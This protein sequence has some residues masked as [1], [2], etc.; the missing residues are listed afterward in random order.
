MSK[1]FC[2]SSKIFYARPNPDNSF[3]VWF[4]DGHTERWDDLRIKAEL[5]FRGLEF[6]KTQIY[7]REDRLQEKD[8]KFK[9]AIQKLNDNLL[10]EISTIREDMK[11]SQMKFQMYHLIPKIIDNIFGPALI[12]SQRDKK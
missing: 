5:N 9:E 7:F 6:L 2:L 4:S 10:K 1:D 3:W 11:V 8:Q 12:H